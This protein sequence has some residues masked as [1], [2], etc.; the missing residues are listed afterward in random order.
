MAR[1]KPMPGETSDMQRDRITSEESNRVLGILQQRQVFSTGEFG[2]NRLASIEAGQDTT[3][4]TNAS[5]AWD[6]AS[7]KLKISPEFLKA[8]DTQRK[9]MTEDAKVEAYARFGLAPPKVATAAPAAAKAAPAKTVPASQIP[10]GTTFGK[11]VPGKGTEVLKDGKVI[12]YA[13]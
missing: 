13:N 7:S 11:V 1:E 4:Q 10:A 12:G 5:N 2:G 3:R 8:N 9:Q 6:K